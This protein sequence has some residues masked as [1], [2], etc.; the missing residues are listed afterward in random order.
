RSISFGLRGRNAEEPFLFE[1]LSEG[2]KQLLAV[3]GAVTLTNQK[4]NL[5]LLDEPDTHLNPHWSWDYPGM[6]AQ[7]FRQEQQP[8][9]TVLM[10]THD[11]VMISGLTR[12]QVLLAHPPSD[13]TPM[14]TR[15]QRN[16]RGQGIANLLCSKEFFSLPSSLD[17]ETQKLLDQRLRISIKPKLDAADK[18][19]LMELNQQL[20]FITPGVS[21]RDPDYVAFLRQRHQSTQ[22]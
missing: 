9:S 10:A 20:E 6:L 5:V 2:E 12:D 16:P 14:F 13:N 18:A 7:A 8:R 3:V 19:R 17:K 21:E 1:Q 15:P 22:P 4:D 11:P